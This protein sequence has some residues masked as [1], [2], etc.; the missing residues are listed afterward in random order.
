MSK[1]IYV[2][3]HNPIHLLKFKELTE[4][5]KIIAKQKFI[6]EILKDNVHLVWDTPNND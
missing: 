4:D 2:Y 5:A 1:G 3:I 6:D